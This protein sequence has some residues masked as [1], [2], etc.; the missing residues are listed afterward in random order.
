VP[1]APPPEA[2]FLSPTKQQPFQRP[3]SPRIILQPI[4]AERGPG[5]AGSAAD[6]MYLSSIK[7]DIQSVCRCAEALQRDL[8]MQR[9]PACS[10]PAKSSLARRPLTPSAAAD[11]GVAFRSDSIEAS[12]SK[13]LSSAD[14]SDGARARPLLSLFTPPAFVSGAKP[15]LK[16]Q[17]LELMMQT[18]DESGKVAL[19]LTDKHVASDSSATASALSKAGACAPF[20]H[21]IFVTFPRSYPLCSAVS[22]AGPSCSSRRQ[23]RCVRSQT[24]SSRRRRSSP[25]ASR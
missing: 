11:P 1:N 13:I 2:L 3:S 14:A 15:A 25:S 23:R 24:S 16:I 12:L 21:C 19:A 18:L 7:Q 22:R 10:L 5:T 6:R 17:A 9:R 4:A 8:D 20:P